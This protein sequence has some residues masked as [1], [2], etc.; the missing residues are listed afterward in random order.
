MRM[1][2]TIYLFMFNDYVPH[3]DYFIPYVGKNNTIPP[4]TGNGKH[5]T[6]FFSD[7][8]IGMVY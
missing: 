6:F 5:T 3:I 7:G 4:M 8:D 1:I 2:Y